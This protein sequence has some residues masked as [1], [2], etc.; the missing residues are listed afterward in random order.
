M[1]YSLEDTKSL[2]TSLAKNAKPG[3]C[4]CLLGDLGAGKTEFARSFIQSI[5]GDIK[6]SSP[7]YN[8][9]LNYDN[10]YHFDLYRIKHESELEE[11]G[12]EDALKNGI[13]LIEWP[14]I[15]ASF[16]PTNKIEITFEVID[17]Q[18]RKITISQ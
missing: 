3:D 2:A 11:I 15:A 8:I 6:V 13:C 10:I 1:I 18:S 17:D 7:T 5:C 12:L 16:L 4:Y 9:V 14:Q